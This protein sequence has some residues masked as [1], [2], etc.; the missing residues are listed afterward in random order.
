MSKNK[1]QWINFV[2][3]M[4]KIGQKVA[5]F[6]YFDENKNANICTG[7]V[8]SGEEATKQLCRWGYRN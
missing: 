4:P 5:L 6:T 2:D 7:I 1:S 8:L 3:E